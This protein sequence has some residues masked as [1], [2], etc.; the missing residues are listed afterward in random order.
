M[1]NARRYMRGYLNLLQS[2]ICDTLT[3]V[4]NGTLPERW[5]T[6]PETLISWIIINSDL[7]TANVI[8]CIDGCWKYQSAISKIR[9]IIVIFALHLWSYASEIR[10]HFLG[11]TEIP[12]KNTQWPIVGDYLKTT[13]K[14]QKSADGSHAPRNSI[15]WWSFNSI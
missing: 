5:P 8:I 15:F 10:E 4:N 11:V 3:F 2:K 13:T 12:Q 9:S 7:C 14:C 1:K 6:E